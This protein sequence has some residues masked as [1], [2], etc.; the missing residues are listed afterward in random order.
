[1]RPTTARLAVQYDRGKGL[2]HFV[3]N[4][5]AQLFEHGKTHLFDEMGPDRFQTVFGW[6]RAS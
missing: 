3:G 6:H 4:R 5:C 1:M 2:S